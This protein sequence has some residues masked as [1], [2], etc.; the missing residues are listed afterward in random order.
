MCRNEQL[1]L[2]TGIVCVGDV[3]SDQASFRPVNFKNTEPRNEKCKH[4]ETICLLWN[5]DPE[6]FIEPEEVRR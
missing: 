6:M 5:L 1:E 3:N 4:S 2:Y